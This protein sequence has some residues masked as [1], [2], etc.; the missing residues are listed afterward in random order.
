MIQYSFNEIRIFSDV[1]ILLLF[2]MRKNKRITYF[3]INII[4]YM[5][6]LNTRINVS[7]RLAKYHILF[8]NFSQRQKSN[9]FTS[10]VSF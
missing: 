7:Y 10:G 1:F 6:S 5:I 3:Y 2:F 9:I 8:Y 4:S